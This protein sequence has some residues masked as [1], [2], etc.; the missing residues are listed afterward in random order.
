MGGKFTHKWPVFRTQPLAFKADEDV[1][2]ARVQ[3]LQ[4]LGFEEV[5]FVS[6]EEGR[7]GGVRVGCE[8]TDLLVGG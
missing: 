6:R 3:G 7:E 1:D 4:A 2:L 8:L 5:G